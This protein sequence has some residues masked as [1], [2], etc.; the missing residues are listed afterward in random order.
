MQRLRR[1]RDIA[2]TAI[3]EKTTGNPE[4]G[5]LAVMKRAGVNQPHAG[6]RRLNV[7]HRTDRKYTLTLS[8]H[9]DCQIVPNHR[10]TPINH[11]AVIGI[12]PWLNL[13]EINDAVTKSAQREE[14]RM[15]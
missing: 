3:T 6:S 9:E 15:R 8:L 5:M 1:A 11:A 13:R 7:R 4:S 2:R 14:V 10:R 12:P